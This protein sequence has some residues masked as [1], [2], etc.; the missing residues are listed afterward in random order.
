[1]PKHIPK[2]LIKCLSKLK[3]YPSK[4]QL[5]V[6]SSNSFSTSKNLILSNCKQPRD[7]SFAVDRNKNDGVNTNNN[8]NNNVSGATLSDIDQFLYE[9]F[10]SLYI[11]DEEDDK[12]KDEDCDGDKIPKGLSLD[13][14][15]LIE[16]PVNLYGSHPFY[17]EAHDSF[18]TNSE[19]IVTSTST[20]SSPINCS[21]N[22]DSSTVSTDSN[23]VKLP[24]DS[25]AMLR[26]SPSPYGDFRRSMQEVVEVQG[27][28]QATIDWDFLE[29]LL[30]CYLRLNEKKSYKFILR[31]FVDLV[32]GLRQN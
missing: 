19:D 2:S 15:R 7:L 22:H 14:P 10:R 24:G 16:P 5:L 4:I 9:N 11:N 28:Q 1:M 32:V 8:N 18:T 29:K 12:K 25:I 21:P 3:K 13:S 30:F 31:A 26:H 6:L 27:Q 17:E 20:S 23:Y